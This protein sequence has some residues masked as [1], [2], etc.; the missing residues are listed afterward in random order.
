MRKQIKFRG[1][2][3]DNN[4]WAEG[5]L[6]VE[7]PP[8]QCFVTDS[9]DKNK[10]FI[11]KS[12]FADWNMPR[13]FTAAEVYKDSIGQFTGI[14]DKNEI[15]IYEGDIVKLHLFTQELGAGLGVEEGEREMIGVIEYQDLGLSFKEAEDDEEWFYLVYSPGMIHEESFEVIGNIYEN[16]ELLTNK[17]N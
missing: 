7:N 11:G 3:I 6:I 17:S 12:G 1:K 2:R 13:P 16:P 5:C 14:K 9:E 8:L 10:Y 15:E 4:E